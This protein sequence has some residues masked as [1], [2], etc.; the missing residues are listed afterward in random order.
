[1]HLTRSGVISR[2]V[3]SEQELL[4]NEFSF[5]T[6]KLLA[7]QRI[8]KFYFLSYIEIEYN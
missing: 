7:L 3:S 4:S 8:F 6:L 2:Y 1:M 5:F